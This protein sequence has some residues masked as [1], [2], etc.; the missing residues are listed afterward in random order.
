MQGKKILPSGRRKCKLHI[1][2]D[3]KRNSLKHCYCDIS[4]KLEKHWHTVFFLWTSLSERRKKIGLH[5]K[6]KWFGTPAAD[7][8]LTTTWKDL[9]FRQCF[10]FHTKYWHRKTKHDCLTRT[11]KKECEMVGVVTTGEFHIGL[12]LSVDPQD[13]G[14]SASILTKCNRS[15]IKHYQTNWSVKSRSFGL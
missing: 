14:R 11:S 15:V 9:Y 4:V 12:G 7:C 2:R 8:F 10:G 6:G 5:S 1:F 13:S 3:C